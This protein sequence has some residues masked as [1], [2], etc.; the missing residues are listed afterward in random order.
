M[1]TYYR[2]LAG[3]LTEMAHRVEESRADLKAA[4]WTQESRTGSQPI[5]RRVRRQDRPEREGGD[6]ED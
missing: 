6:S 4:M 5:L 1:K 2:E 3:R